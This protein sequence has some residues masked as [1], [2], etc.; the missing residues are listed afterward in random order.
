M[1]LMVP[2]VNVAALKDTTLLNM[3]I[4]AL[5]V[6]ITMVIVLRASRN[7]R[8]EAATISPALAALFSV[9]NLMAALTC[10]GVQTP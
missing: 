8:P 6:A 2:A 5:F 10:F 9:F 4:F 7:N 1:T 3:G